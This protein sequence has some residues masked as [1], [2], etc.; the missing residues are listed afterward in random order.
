MNKFKVEKE[1]EVDGFRCVVIGLEAGHRCGY[2]K[3]P[4]DH[5]YYG[6]DYDDIHV[7]IHGGW[8]YSEYTYN[9]YPIESDKN[10]WWIGF[11]CAH[12]YDAKDLELIKSFGDT[13]RTRVYMDMVER[14]PEHGEI[15]TTEYVE[16]ELRE[17]VKELKYMFK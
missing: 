12:C 6:V 16:N 1:F 15:R 5:K 4:K 10:S 11:D 17:A 3:I 14:F 13:K 2:I 8:T 7:D 9:N